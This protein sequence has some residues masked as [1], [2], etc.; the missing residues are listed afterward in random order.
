MVESV[1]ATARNNDLMTVFSAASEPSRSSLKTT[2][3]A[4]SVAQ[5]GCP[6]E[7]ADEFPL[8]EVAELRLRTAG[9][10]AASAGVAQSSRIP[11][12]L[13]WGRVASCVPVE[14][15]SRPTP[16][17]SLTLPNCYNNPSYP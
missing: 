13:H 3:P 9:C 10:G 16:H 11:R 8:F 7:G 14:H 2:R 4:S 17:F 12:L 5:T 15:I 1:S 6:R